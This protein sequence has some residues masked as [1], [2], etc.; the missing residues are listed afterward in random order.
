MREGK[1]P[2]NGSSDS[3]RSSAEG[4]RRRGLV[5]PGLGIDGLKKRGEEGVCM[6]VCYF[7]LFLS[8]SI[9]VLF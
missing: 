3:L 1:W 4:S 6:C 5:G 2:E 7:C 8:I 9:L